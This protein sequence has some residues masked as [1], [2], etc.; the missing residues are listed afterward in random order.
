MECDID[1]KTET[2][3][4][5]NQVGSSQSGPKPMITGIIPVKHQ[6]VSILT[7]AFSSEHHYVQVQPH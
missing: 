5:E 2:L 3:D 6:S 1:G 7:L 4:T